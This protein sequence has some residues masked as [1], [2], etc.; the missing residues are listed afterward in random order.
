MA[1]TSEDPQTDRMIVGLVADPGLAAAVADDVAD[2]LPATLAREVSDSVTWEVWVC[3]EALPLNDHGDIPLAEAGRERMRREGWDLMVCLTELPRRAGTRPLVSEAS[4]AWGVAL[5]SLP[6]IGWLRLRAHVRNTIVH[7]L[8]EMAGHVREPGQAA[9]GPRRPFRRRPTELVSPVRPVTPADEDFDLLLVLTGARGKA[10]L[11]FGMVRN[12]RPWRLVPHLKS[13][14]AGAAAGSAFGLFYGSLW[15]I[16]DALSPG[17]LAVI[18]VFAVAI[19]AAWLIVYNN[20]W[21]RPAG[22]ADRQKA[23]LYNTA[24]IATVSLGVWFA[25]LLLFMVTLAAAGA[26]VDA[27]LLHSE[28]GHAVTW[29]DYAIIAWMAS[30]V[31]IVAGA[32]GSTFE[33]DDAVHQATYSRREQERQVRRH[34]RDEKASSVTR[35]RRVST[36]DRAGNLRLPGGHRS[37]LRNPWTTEFCT[38]CLLMFG[39]PPVWNS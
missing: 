33:S 39:T 8:H 34:E 32:L 26:A 3:S 10:R 22:Q 9:R 5:I 24:T 21:E 1:R 25:Y 14:V 7:V 30:S 37:T 28:V 16:A 6:A 4:S 13:A 36:D 19:M 23:V 27:G 2:E 38:R 20:L 15:K 31:G 11:L 12:N 17:R 35:P 29:G 18:N